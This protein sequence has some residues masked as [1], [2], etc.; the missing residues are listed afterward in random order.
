M[1]PNITFVGVGRMGADMARCLKDRGYSVVAVYDSHA[2]VAAILALE[3]GAQQV[4]T[5][6]RPKGSCRTR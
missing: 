3:L 1:K 2:A 5:L 6:E 4:T